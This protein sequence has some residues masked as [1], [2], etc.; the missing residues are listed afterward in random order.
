ML[1]HSKLQL[2]TITT[3]YQILKSTIKKHKQNI[4][5]IINII[6]KQFKNKTKKIKHKSITKFKNHISKTK[7]SIKKIH[8]LIKKNKHLILSNNIKKTLSYN[9][10]IK[11][12]QKKKQKIKTSIP[13]FKQ[14]NLTTNKL[15]YLFKSLKTPKKKNFI[16]KNIIKNTKKNN[17]PKIK[18]KFL[19]IPN[20]LTT[21]NN[22]SNHIQHI[23]YQK[24]NKI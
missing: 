19:L 1:S 10:N 12:Y 7:Q 23:Y 16:K 21:I 9:T 15:Y 17:L 2:S 22:N 14:I 24:T 6:T 4:H 11:K 5:H 8:N 3:K 18:K 13:N 20:I